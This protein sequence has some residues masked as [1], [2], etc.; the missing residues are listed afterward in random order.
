MAFLSLAMALSACGAR[1]DDDLRQ[2]AADQALGRGGG[3]SG[4]TSGI[5]GGST[6]DGGATGTSGDGGATGT[7]GAA[8]GTGATGAGTTGTGTSGAGTSGTGSTTT[9]TGAAPAP[10]GGNGGAVD[11]GVTE[12]S[13]LLGNV[14]DLSGP[15]PG[16]FEGA[17]LGTQ[18]HI[19]KINSEG[20]IFGRKLKLSVGDGQLEC[21]QNKAQH[22]ARV[23]KVFAFVGSFSLFDNCGNEVLKANPGIPDVHSALTK[24]AQQH[25]SNFSVAPLGSGWR[26]GPL[27]Y[28]KGKY[29]EKFKKIGTIFAGVGGGSQIWEGTEAAIV[30]VGGKVLYK[31]AFQPTDT[32]FT[33]DIVRMRN[34]GVEM[35]YVNAADGATSARIV[36]AAK[37]QG[38]NWPIIFGAVSYEQGFLKSA[39][40]N[41]EGVFND[42]QFALFFNPDEASRVPV[43]K[44]YQTWMDRAAP[45]KRKDLFSVYGWASVDLFVQALKKAG[46]KAKRA[47]VLAALRTFTKFNAGGLLA[48]ANPAGKKPAT[49]WVLTQVKD[50]KYIRVDSPASGF[51]CDG[52]YFSR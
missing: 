39:G 8:T 46:P 24:P 42:Q 15:V 16:L 21:G 27:N 34:E 22:A 25:A 10:P 40:A 2:A 11:V 38:V 20:G 43:V 41:A 49:C 52:A 30:S 28:Y 48:E 31:R 3:A 35:I 18:A 44:D 12:D 5:D 7:S 14:A 51:R 29:G 4:S 32:D 50:G 47:D 23:D 13:I 19:A 45:G 37:S 36:N 6:G 33:A 9:G 17:V 1:V 26:T